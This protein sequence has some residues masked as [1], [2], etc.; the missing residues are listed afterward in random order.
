[1]MYKHVFQWHTILAEKVKSQQDKMPIILRL[2]EYSKIKEN[3]SER[4]SWCF[5]WQ[6]LPSVQVNPKIKLQ[7]I[8]AGCDDG[9]GT[10]LSIKLWLVKGGRKRDY[11]HELNLLDATYSDV[12][13]T[14]VAGAITRWV[15]STDS[16]RATYEKEREALEKVRRKENRGWDLMSKTQRLHVAILNQISDSEHH[17]VQTNP[18]DLESDC[19][20]KNEDCRVLICSSPCFVS[21]KKLYTSTVSCRYLKDDNIYFSIKAQ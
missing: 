7:V 18:V 19:F 9:K 5:S 16:K 17:T 8:P 20:L 21:N 6:N 1:M 10:H 14:G 4:R 11:E 3:Y 15:L 2:S 12:A 13:Q